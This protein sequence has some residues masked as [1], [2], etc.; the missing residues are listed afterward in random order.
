METKAEII[1]RKQKAAN[2]FAKSKEYDRALYETTWHGYSVY[3]AILDSSTIDSC[4]GYPM[5]IL[6]SDTSAP[7]WATLEEVNEILVSL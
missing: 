7:R 6:I 3:V 1:A 4:G 5:Y 2:S